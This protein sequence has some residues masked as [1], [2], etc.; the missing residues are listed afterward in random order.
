MVAAFRQDCNEILDSVEQAEAGGVIDEVEFDVRA[1]SHRCYAM[2][3]ERAVELRSRSWERKAVPAC[4]CGQR[5][6]MVRRMPKTVVS[7]VGEL[8]FER[9]HYYCDTCK[10]SRWPFD[11]EMGIAGG[12]TAGAVRLMTRAGAK[13]SFEEARSDLQEFAEIRVSHETIRCVTEGVAHALTAEQAAGR[14]LGE[15][16]SARFEQADRAYVSM[17]GEHT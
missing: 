15:E 14:L 6:R 17:V 9:R 16:S 13:V 11:E 1:M 3:L 4:S 10:T 8:R 12:W 5:M 7:V 2:V